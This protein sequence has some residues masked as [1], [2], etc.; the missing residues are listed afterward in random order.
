MQNEEQSRGSSCLGVSG[1]LIEEALGTH[2]EQMGIFKREKHAGS[3]LAKNK[4]LG[5]FRLF[6]FF[7]KFVLRQEFHSV[8]QAGVQWHHLAHCNLCLPGS[9]IFLPQPPKCL[10]L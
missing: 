4:G 1:S 2:R 5:L 10:E 3:T 9:A 8:S 7:K 6:L